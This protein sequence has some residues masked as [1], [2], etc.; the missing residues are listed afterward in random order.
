MRPLFVALLGF[1]VLMVLLALTPAPAAL[2]YGPRG[3]HTLERAR[4][5]LVASGL[6]LGVGMLTT[7]ALGGLQ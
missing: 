7:F 4:L 2:S 5:A 6:A 3:G 1:A